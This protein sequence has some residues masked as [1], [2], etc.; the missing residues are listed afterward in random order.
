MDA[1]EI[2][3][4]PRGEGEKRAGRRRVGPPAG[5]AQRSQDLGTD[6]VCSGARADPPLHHVPPA[7]VTN[8]D[9]KPGLLKRRDV[10]AHHLAGEAQSAGGIGSRCFLNSQLHDLETER[11]EKHC[12]SI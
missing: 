6:E 11:M 2:S 10:V 5:S 4:N 12:N 7:H 9:Q 1:P 8:G 3:L